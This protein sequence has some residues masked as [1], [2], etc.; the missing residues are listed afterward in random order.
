MGA[1]SGGTDVVDPSIDTG[2]TG[3]GVTV[4]TS[5]AAG[6]SAGAL[7]GPYGAIAGGVLGAIG[8]LMAASD[9]AALDNEKAQVAKEQADEIQAREVANENLK[10]QAAY[11]AKLAFGAAFAGSG[12]AGTGIGSQLEIQRQTD[13]NNMISNE[14][15]Q[16][17]QK[18]LQTQAGIE[19]QLGSEVSTAGYINAGGSVLGG[20]TRAYGMSQPNTQ[21]MALPGMGGSFG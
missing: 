17:Q 6:A 12:K 18:M 11:R 1:S 21:T 5:A 19:T 13:Q 9:Q 8:G 16:F 14:E 10:N 3:A 7:L 2:D 4:G 20:A 15:S